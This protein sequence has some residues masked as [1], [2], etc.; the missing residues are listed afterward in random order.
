MKLRYFRKLE[1]LINYSSLHQLMLLL[2]QKVNKAWKTYDARVFFFRCHGHFWKIISKFW[3]KNR[4]LHNG[5]F[6]GIKSKERKTFQVLPFSQCCCRSFAVPWRVVSTK[7]INS[8]LSGLM[9]LVVS[10]SSSTLLLLSVSPLMVEAVLP[11]PLSGTFDAILMQYLMR[12]ATQEADKRAS[13]SWSQQCSMVSQ[14]SGIPWTLSFQESLMTGLIL[15]FIR[16][17][18][19]YGNTGQLKRYI[20][21]T[22]FEIFIFCP[23]IQLWFPE[24][25]CRIVLGENS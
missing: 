18:K 7:G 2:L 19:T 13:A 23:K 10:V 16:S 8:A 12:S 1:N 15:L 9:L 20:I 22:L 25:N 17:W 5:N 21:I 14:N 6:R 11:T 4:S 3:Q 24:K